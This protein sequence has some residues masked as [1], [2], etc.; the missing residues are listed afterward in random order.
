V[1]VDGPDIHAFSQ[2]REGASLDTSAPLIIAWHRDQPADIAVLRPE[3][4]DEIAIEDSGSYTLPAGAFW[5]D[6]SSA[7]LHTVRL[8]R[9]NQVVPEG[10]TRDSSWSVTLENDVHVI[11]PPLPL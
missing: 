8:V 2:P 1:R 11:E 10:A 5:S 6:N 7:R 3:P 9:T 4:A